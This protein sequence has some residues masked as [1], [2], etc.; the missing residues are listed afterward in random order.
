MSRYGDCGR[1]ERER[2]KVH[3]IRV[4]SPEK[5]VTVTKT[6]NK[7]SGANPLKGYKFRQN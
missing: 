5:E 1:K 2:R 6:N 4:R 7:I 3:W